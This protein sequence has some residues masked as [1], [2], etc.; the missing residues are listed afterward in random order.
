[1]EVTMAEKRDYYDV[2]GVDKSASADEIKKAYRKL[3]KKYHPDIN[4]EPN[5]EDKFKEV[6]EAYEI[7][8]DKSKRQQ[9]DQ[10]GH[11]GTGQG[12][13]GFGGGQGYGGAGGFGG[14]GF[15][16]IFDTFFGGGRRS[17]PTAPRQGEDLRYTMNLKFEEAIFGTEQTIKYKRE[18]TCNNCGGDGAKPGTHPETCSNCGGS[19]Q[20]TQRQQTPLGTFQTQTACDVCGGSGQ[21]IKEK[22]DICNGIG[23][24]RETHSETVNVPAGVEDNNQIRLSGRG[25][26]GANNGPYGDL[27]IV[28]KVKPSD[29]FERNGPQ[30]YYELPLNFV[31]ATLGD[32]VKVPT[33]H[34][35]VMYKVP[36]GTQNGT[37][38]RLKDKGAPKLNGSGNGNQIV[39]VKVEIPT[40]LTEEQT[41]ILR[42]F[43]K[44]S[45]IE[46]EEQHDDSFFKKVKDVFNKD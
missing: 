16:D 13:G 6:S 11:A 42:E 4:D 46:V 45:E 8:S 31:Q 17:D 33:V 41:E 36:S 1:M 32:E 37:K 27:Y 7:L 20:T 40:S 26:V 10:F 28:F 9:Y 22:C 44:A 14:G 43:A 30:I 12:A 39:T 19:G 2:L 29:T 21:I 15:E 5:A 18:E 25:N 38:F 24:T 3:S 23:H 34:G 35:D